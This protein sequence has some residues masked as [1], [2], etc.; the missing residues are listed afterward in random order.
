MS[1]FSVC[2]TSLPSAPPTLL[3]RLLR[4]LPT[5]R[6]ALKYGLCCAGSVTLALV[7]SVHFVFQGAEWCGNHV[8]ESG[9]PNLHSLSLGN[10]ALPA[11]V[12]AL[13]PHC[14][15]ARPAIPAKMLSVV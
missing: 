1:L 11:M 15:Q 2:L 8:L 6:Q 5:S 13:T 12:T 3:Q 10:G 14:G 7:L 9:K 4:R